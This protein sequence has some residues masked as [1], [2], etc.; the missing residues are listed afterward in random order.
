[1]ERTPP[2]AS[3]PVERMVARAFASW[4]SARVDG[5]GGFAEQAEQDGSIGAVADAGEGERAVQ[6]NDY[7]IRLREEVCGA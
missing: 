6:V 4:M 3:R 2:S 1:M 7:G 5:V